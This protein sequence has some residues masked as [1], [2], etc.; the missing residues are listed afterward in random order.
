MGW[1]RITRCLGRKGSKAKCITFTKKKSNFVVIDEEN[2]QTWFWERGSGWYLWRVGL[3]SFERRDQTSSFSH[4]VSWIY[5][6]YVN[7]VLLW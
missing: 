5:W 4:Q 7:L 3:S 6:S 1:G 2:G